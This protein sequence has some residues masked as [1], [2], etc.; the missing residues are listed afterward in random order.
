MEEEKAIQDIIKSIE[1]TISLFSRSGRTKTETW[2]TQQL[3]ENLGTDFKEDEL[4]HGNNPPD[5]VFRNEEFEIKEVDEEGRKRGDELKKKL[6]KAK[7][8][9]SL[10]DLMAPYKFK[11]ITLQEVVNRIHKK[12]K[13][14][15]YAPDFCK[16]TNI[17][18]YINYTLIGKHEY[19]ISERNIWEKWR[20]VSMITNNNFSCVFLASNDI[21]KFMKSA[22]GILTERHSKG[23]D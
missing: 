1:E 12:L 4:K 3:L 9:K 8:A 6:E 7:S 15:A 14:F 5:V 22:V 19:E 18:F 16:N 20:S 2:V 11:E 17:L 23:K 21:A 13:E 10:K